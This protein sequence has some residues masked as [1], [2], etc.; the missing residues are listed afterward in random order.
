MYLMLY[1]LLSLMCM[2]FA[3][4]LHKDEEKHVRACMCLN[5]D[6]HLQ[7]GGRLLKTDGQKIPQVLV[8]S[9]LSMKWNLAKNG[10]GVYESS[11]KMRARARISFYA[12]TSR[13]NVLR[14]ML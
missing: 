13:Q 10:Y 3:S 5:L 9:L 11:S 8:F 4:F 7:A 12:V 2:L 6:S 14:T 1:L